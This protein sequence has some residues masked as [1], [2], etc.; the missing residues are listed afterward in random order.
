M[1]LETLGYLSLAFY[2]GMYIFK[3]PRA[4]IL[5][6]VGGDFFAL[7]HY[8]VLGSL[9]SGLLIFITIIRMILSVYVTDK[10]LKTVIF[11]YLAIVWVGSLWTVD[12]PAEYFG[13]I[14]CSF[15][16][17]AAFGRDKFL[18]FR[19]GLIACY[20]FWLAFAVAVD[21]LPMILSYIMIVG[22]N[23]LTIWYHSTSGPLTHHPFEDLAEHKA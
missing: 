20:G 7:L 9:A 15:A 21:S 2:V 11:G 10:W 3:A 23:I 8:I 12:F 4:S 16:A 5:T 18:M 1:L 6:E 14:G 22:A 19:I 17:L 13:I